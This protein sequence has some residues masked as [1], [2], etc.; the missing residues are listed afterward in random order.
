MPLGPLHL[1][2]LRPLPYPRQ[3]GTLGE[4]LR[5]RRHELGLRQK[6]VARA[7]GV[8]NSTVLHW[9][10]DR[11]TPPV[12]YVPS[13]IEFLGYDPCPPPKN[14]GERLQA[15]R[16]FLGLSRK[17]AARLLGV[18]EG[19]LARWEAGACEPRREHLALVSDVLAVTREAELAGQ[20]QSG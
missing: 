18:D 14:L 11:T 6:D 4:C 16:R 10:I 17:R 9:E 12:R 15:K 7:L 19:T 2:A 5:K 13:I 8:S 3:P 1:K 20:G